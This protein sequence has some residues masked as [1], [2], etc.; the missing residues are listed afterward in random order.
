MVKINPRI[1]LPVPFSALLAKCVLFFHGYG[2]LST[3]PRG[4]PRTHYKECAEHP[5]YGV[6][7][8]RR[9]QGHNNGIFP[10]NYPPDP[11]QGLHRTLQSIAA[12]EP[13][14]WQPELPDSYWYTGIHRL[15]QYWQWYIPANHLQ[16][17]STTFYS[18]HPRLQLWKA[19]HQTSQRTNP[20]CPSLRSGN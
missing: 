13:G 7:V 4:F 9:N 18:D 17:R 5:A 16:G 8:V 12:R 2:S 10:G 20:A 19:R 3:Y 6:V 14:P 11:G 15:P 1:P